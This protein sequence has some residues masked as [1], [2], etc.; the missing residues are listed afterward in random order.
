MRSAFH[1]HDRVQLDPGPGMTKQSFADETNINNIIRRY[2]RDQVLTHLNKY[3]GK[4]GDFIGYSDYHTSLNLLRDADEAFS[5]IPAGIRS[6]FDNDPAKFLEFAQNGQNHEELVK[7]GL[8]NARP[9]EH[10]ATDIP[11]D[12]LPGDTPPVTAAPPPPEA[13]PAPS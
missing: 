2:E 9:R 12:P 6:R 3:E 4:Y 10:Q 13:A 1:P 5:S 8:A 7:M 11:S